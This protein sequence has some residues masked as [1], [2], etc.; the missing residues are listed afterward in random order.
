MKRGKYEAG[1]RPRGTRAM[2]SLNK[3]GRAVIGAVVTLIFAY[4]CARVW[5]AYHTGFTWKEMDWNG[6]GRTTLIEVLS[7][8]DI[9]RRTVK[10]GDSTCTEYYA[11]KD[12]LRV[13]LDCPESP[14]KH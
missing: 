1:V 12:G 2:Y 14:P 5:A 8:S 9:G 4:V 3:W 13:R 11:M 6:D 7:S 10:Q